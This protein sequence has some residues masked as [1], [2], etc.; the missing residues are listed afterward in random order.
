MFGNSVI[1]QQRKL[2]ELLLQ[3]N[4]EK[5]RTILRL[6]A[7]GKAKDLRE[8]A[9]CDPAPLTHEWTVKG[10][11]NVGYDDE[12]IGEIISALE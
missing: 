10:D 8:F 6:V 1:K 7:M 4:A 9:E 12:K 2:I 3:Q 5:D 11:D